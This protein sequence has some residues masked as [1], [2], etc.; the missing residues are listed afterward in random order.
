MQCLGG[1]RGD[2]MSGYPLT[3]GHIRRFDTFLTA[4]FNPARVASTSLA[5]VRDIV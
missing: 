5:K 3:I 2:C 1:N 4:G